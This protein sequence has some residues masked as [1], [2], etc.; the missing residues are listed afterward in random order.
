MTANCDA[1]CGIYCGACSILRHGET[2]RA[3]G[4]VACCGSIPKGDLACSGCKSGAVYAGCRTCGLRDC[5]ARKG[6]AHCVDCA[7]YPCR[8]FRNW[9]SVARHLPHVRE[10]AASL[11]AIKSGGVDAWLA[12]QRARWSCSRCG[13]AFS[14]Y[15]ATCSECGGSLAAQ[16]YAMS[17]LRRLLCRWILPMVYRK[18]KA[19][20]PQT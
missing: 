13:A 12:A 3:D 11:A 5:A 20:N 8:E 9:Q 10:A 4:L 15:S 7:D 17:G 19:K 18:G 14:W 6:L 1:Y 16:A 2:G